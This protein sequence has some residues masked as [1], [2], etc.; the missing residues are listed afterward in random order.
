MSWFPI[1]SSDWNKEALEPGTT[2]IINGRNKKSRRK[3]NLPM[4]KAQGDEY[5]L[6]KLGQIKPHSIEDIK[7]DQAK[8]LQEA[9][10]KASM[11]TDILALKMPKNYDLSKKRDQNRAIILIKK[12]SIFATELELVS[13]M[14]AFI[15]PR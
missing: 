15:F 9:A 2:D 3:T 10:I 11:I 4:T 6:K 14:K 7:R 1:K 12:A 13:F 5:E 8:R